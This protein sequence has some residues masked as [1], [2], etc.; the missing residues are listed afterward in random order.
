MAFQKFPEGAA[1]KFA[2]IYMLN[3]MAPVVIAIRRGTIYTGERVE[4]ADGLL[5][6]YLEIAGLTGIILTGF[7]WLYFRWLSRDFADQL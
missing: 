6:N 3:P 1:S 5:L 2:K 7:G 4:L